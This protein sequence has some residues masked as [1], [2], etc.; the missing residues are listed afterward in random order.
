MSTSN[1]KKWSVIS[2]Q[3]I[4]ITFHLLLIV[5]PFAFT[6]IND[7]LFEFNKMILTYLFAVVIVGTWIMRMILE[8]RFI[9]KRT[10]F[11]IPIAA[12]FISQL[13]STIF[14]IHPYTSFFGYYS[15]FHGGLLSTITYI[16]LFYA[17]ISNVPARHLPKYLLSLA[18]SSIGVA[19]YA[20]PESFGHS[21]S[22]F[23]ITNG[24]N[25]GV[26]CWI[27][28]VKTRIFGTFG[29]PNWLAAYAITIIPVT[30]ALAIAPLQKKTTWL[31]WIFVLATI[32]LFLT[33]LFT[34][35]RSGFGGLGVGLLLFGLG[36]GWLYVTGKVSIAKTWASVVSIGLACAVALAVFGSVLTPSI[37]QVLQPPATVDT[38]TTQ[39]QPESAPVV[40]R[41][42]V[43][44]TD[45][46]EIRAIVWQGAVNIFKR[47]PILG[48]G[49]ETFAYS[50]YLD[51]PMAHNLVSEWDFL[52]NKAHNEFLNF[53]ATTGAVGLITYVALLVWFSVR[54]IRNI[55]D[56]KQPIEH[57]VLSLG[58]LSGVA[59]LS[60]SNYF[61][62][63]TV[64]VAVLMF[65][66]FV[67]VELLAKNSTQAI[68][69]VEEE[70]VTYPKSIQTG[71][72]VGA[73]LTSLVILYMVWAVITMWTAD[74]AYTKGK[75]YIQAGQ[76]TVGL[77]LLQTAVRQSPQEALFY[78]ELANTYSGYAAQLAQ[79]DATTAAQLAQ[80]AIV[81]TDTTLALNPRH[82]N[83]HKSNA[84]VYITLAELESKYL[85]QAKQALSTAIDL[86]PTDAKLMYNLG[87]VQ[88]ALDE[89]D[90]GLATIE[91][92][93]QMK[94]NYL[95]ARLELA[96]QYEQRQEWNKATDQ[97]QI[98]LSE[99]VPG[100]TD[101]QAKL[102]AIEASASAQSSN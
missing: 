56:Q 80:A 23:L 96:K 42:D 30:L 59:A 86:A 1:L 20:I 33:T 52:Y 58:L 34:R 79:Q 24:Q 12:F 16:A 47:Y 13:L 63:S 7:E 8:E 41:L 22:C 31:K 39:V 71:Q 61:G 29:Q 83:F 78:D 49:V 73:G 44:G 21:P 67:W 15:R 5:V 28:D 76:P 98:I 64:M 97:Y 87:L 2:Q 38:Q 14:S 26:D 57:R 94:P 74:V 69:D 3:I 40:N 17:F 95:A 55:A 48:S 43:G 100:D 10:S 77:D 4:I 9:F 72:L 62:F 88:I 68:Q 37:S 46:G 60:V 50:Y 101:V 90:V 85:Q 18:L 102:N 35:S 93:V 75:Q 32:L 99:I 45:S 65:L 91:K 84:R 92:S 51:R 81:A 36:L 25:F 27:Q 82:L 89:D 6:W 11:D 70:T 54:A 53:L 66:Y 19:L